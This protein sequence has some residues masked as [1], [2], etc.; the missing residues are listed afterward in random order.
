MNTSCLVGHRRFLVKVSK[1][2]HFKEKARLLLHESQFSE[3]I[4]IMQ[5]NLTM[6]QN[7]SKVKY[8]QLS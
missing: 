8:L 5:T 3:R 4:A 2:D 6:L 1:I 7:A